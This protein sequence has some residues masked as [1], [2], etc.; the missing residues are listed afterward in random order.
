MIL[1]AEAAYGMDLRLSA[2]PAVVA[3]AALFFA[4]AVLIFWGASKGPRAR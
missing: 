3:T 2:E 4:A 1:F